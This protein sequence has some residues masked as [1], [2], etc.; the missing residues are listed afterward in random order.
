MGAASKFCSTLVTY[1][2]QVKPLST[3][4]SYHKTVG[5]SYPGFLLSL[6][7]RLFHDVFVLPSLAVVAGTRW[8]VGR[9]QRFIVGPRLTAPILPSVLTAPALPSVQAARR[10]SFSFFFW[11][12]FYRQRGL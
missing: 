6:G 9:E 2:T 10:W 4:L 11:R 3:M 5:L 8:Y 7:T 12:A 1:P